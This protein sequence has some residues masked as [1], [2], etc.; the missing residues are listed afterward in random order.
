MPRSPSEPKLPTAFPRRTASELAEAL[1]VH[2]N[3]VAAWRKEG[4]PESLDEF[5]WRAWAAAQAA[6]SKGYDCPRDPEPALLQLLANAGVGDYRERQARHQPVLG[7]GPAP[8]PGV[9]A[10]AAKTPTEP[11][12]EQRKALA[13]AIIAETKARSLQRE[14]DQRWHRLVP[15]ESL[16]PLLTAWLQSL[17]DVLLATL[18]EVPDQVATTPEARAQIRNALDRRIRAAREQLAGECE[19]RLATYLEQLAKGAA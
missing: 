18:N 10:A 3:T 12:A 16:H 14:E 15:V 8:E 1:G 7:T 13:D 4:A 6:T 17:N 11:T 9:P 2:R 5:H 19:K